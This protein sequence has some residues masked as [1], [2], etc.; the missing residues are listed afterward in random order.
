MA[1]RPD[2]FLDGHQTPGYTCQPVGTV[3]TSKEGDVDIKRIVVGVDG[4]PPATAAARWAAREAAIRNVELTV[5]HVVHAALRGWPQT[6][7]PAI[8]VPAEFGESQVAQG[9]KVLENALG[10]IAKTT[11]PDQPRRIVTRLCFGA[12]VPTLREFTEGTGQMIVVWPTRPRRDTPGS[13]GFGQPRCAP[14]RTL[15]G[16]GGAPTHHT[17]S[18]ERSTGGR[19]Y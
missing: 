15:P 7:W 9:E 14:R 12:V 2:D 11:G 19:R 18:I 10:V 5:V 13:A 8:P 6:A 3:P 4:S 16:R 17:G 1:Q